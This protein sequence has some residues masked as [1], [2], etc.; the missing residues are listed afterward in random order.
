MNEIPCRLNGSPQPLRAGRFHVSPTIAPGLTLESRIY[1]KAEEGQVRSHSLTPT[2]AVFT[3]EPQEPPRSLQRGL[4]KASPAQHTQEKCMRGEGWA[5]TFSCA[6]QWKVPKKGPW[7]GG[8]AHRALRTTPGKVS[9]VLQG[10]WGTQWKDCPSTSCNYCSTWEPGTLSSA[11]TDQSLLPALPKWPVQDRERLIW[12]LQVWKECRAVSI[13]W[14]FTEYLLSIYCS[15]SHAKEPF[16]PLN[17]ALP[18]WGPS[19][20]QSE[21][22]PSPLGGGKPV[23]TARPK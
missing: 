5:D 22:S 8:W 7:Q 16:T 9:W 2:P 17:L 18:H 14:A 11:S 6:N 20:S 19:L 23:P 13:Y 4:C 3:A 10:T 12:D 21:S 1:P 15:R